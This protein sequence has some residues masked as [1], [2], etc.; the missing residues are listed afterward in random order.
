MKLLY[1][2]ALCFRVGSIHSYM[3]HA[4]DMPK[5]QHYVLYASFT[6]QLATPAMQHSTLQH[7]TRVLLKHM[8]VPI[9]LPQTHCVGVDMACE[10]SCSGKQLY[11]LF[12]NKQATYLNTRGCDS[13]T[14][15]FRRNQNWPVARG[16]QD[17]ARTPS[18]TNKT[19]WMPGQINY[20]AAHEICV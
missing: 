20:N 10:A 18:K 17:P 5:M 1:E 19:V 9:F 13:A 2:T 14:I 16:H 4:Y 12:H 11:A 15:V 3:P 6:P 8:S 7:A